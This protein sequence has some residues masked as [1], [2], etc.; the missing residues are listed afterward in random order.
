[1]SKTRRKSITLRLTL[2]FA[3][4]STA[5]FLLLGLLIGRSVEQH[6]EEQDMEI[7]SAKLDLARHELGKAHSEQDLV[8]IPQQLDEALVGH[9]G[10]AVVV[11]APDGQRLFASNGAD[12]PGRLLAMP[13]KADA[14]RPMEWT[15]AANVPFRGIVTYAA[16]GMQNA[17]PAIVA[18]ATDISHHRQFLDSFRITLWSFVLL[19]AALTGLL[20]WVAVRRGLAP[21]QAIRRQ[22]EGITAQRLDARLAIDTV[23]V[24]LVALAETFNDMLSRLENSFRRL[25]DFSSDLAHEFRTPVSNL[26]TQTQVTLSK[27]RSTDEYQDVLASNSE[28]F[29]RLSRMIADMLFIA[30]ADEGRV[31]LARGAMNLA[32]VVDELLEFYSLISDEKGVVMTRIGE[33]QA[34]GDPLMIRRAI[35]NLLSNALRYTPSGGTIVVRIGKAEGSVVRLAVENTGETIPASHLPRLFDRFYRVD[36]SRHRESDGTGLGLAIIQSI[37]TAHGGTVA[38]RSENALTTFELLIPECWPD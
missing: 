28:E 25:S 19:A 4:I 2:L 13:I 8:A 9:Q 33:A 34:S 38:V 24:E 11:V 31:V 36:A 1:M 14:L 15:T 18:V 12:F 29:E 21:L 3:A 27:V 6:F 23:P 7:L 32:L 37:M 10:L 35:S 22:A 17:R 20:G 16:T 30:K 26:L 5:V